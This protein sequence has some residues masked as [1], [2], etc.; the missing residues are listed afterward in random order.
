[1]S[2]NGE[3]LTLRRKIIEQLPKHALAVRRQPTD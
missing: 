2:K 1:M 3:S